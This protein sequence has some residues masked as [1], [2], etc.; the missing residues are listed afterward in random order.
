VSVRSVLLVLNAVALFALAAYAVMSLRR[1][2]EVK[3]PPNLG[4]PLSDEVLEG[5]RLERVLGW[6]LVFMAVIAVALP[7]YWLREPTRQEESISYFDEGAVERGK[8][9][10]ANDLSEEFNSAVSL[11]CANCHGADA[12]GGS[13]PYVYTPP[14][15]GA[16]D[17]VRLAWAAPALDTVLLR[18]T[19]DEVRDIITFGRPGT[20]MQPWGTP[21]GGP[22]NEQAINDLVAFLRSLQLTPEEAQ[23]QAA[24]RLDAARDAADDGVTSAEETLATARDDLETATTGLDDLRAD[25]DAT[26]KQIADAEQAVADARRGVDRAE[27]SLAWAR[28]WATRR[29]D[30]SDGQLLFEL[31]CARCHTKGWSI[32]DASR[33]DGTQVLGLAGGGGTLGFN[34]RD[35]Q[36]YRRFGTGTT[37][38]RSQV[39]FVTL[40]TE[41]HK[42]YGIG[43]IGSGRMPGFGSMLTTEMIE[44]I[45]D[46]ERNHLDDTTYLADETEE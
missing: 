43:G 29:A 26:P 23:Q 38:R 15:G 34:L 30:V 46:Y 16:S 45:V 36:T 32:F 21:G 14:G 35:G 11:Q 1:S 31:F 12:T 44:Q 27:R 39:E 19:E 2:P 9:L 25:A 37:G 42:A 18:F 24:D 28:D 22:K 8:V 6:A 10:F 40:G 3:D 7:V 41:Q 5:R 20:P 33:P 13:A 4:E 17:V